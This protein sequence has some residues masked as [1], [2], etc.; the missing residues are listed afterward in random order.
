MLTQFL[1]KI[2]GRCAGIIPASIGNLTKLKT[3]H[4]HCNSALVTPPGCPVDT[5]IGM[6]YVDEIEVASFLRFLRY[7]V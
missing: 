3:L 6:C 1:H 4:L 7:L 2:T 5:D